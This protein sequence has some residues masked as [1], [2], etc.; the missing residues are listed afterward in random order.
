VG[1]DEAGGVEHIGK[2]FADAHVFECAGIIFG[3]EQVIAVF[4]VEAFADVFVGVGVGPADADGF[5]GKDEGLFV[6]GV[7]VVFGEDPVKLIGSEEAGEVGV[8][9]EGDGREDGAHN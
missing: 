3:G 4:E 5:F 8:A 7:E 1:D 2:L 6:L 9:V